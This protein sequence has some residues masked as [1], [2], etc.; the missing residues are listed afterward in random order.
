MACLWCS[1]K[2]HFTFS[3]LA[4]LLYIYITWEW[5]VFAWHHAHERPKLS[6][7]S[8]RNNHMISENLN[9]FIKYQSIS[10]G[11]DNIEFIFIHCRITRDI[12]FHRRCWWW[13]LINSSVFDFW[14]F[15][16]F[17]HIVYEKCRN[18]KWHWHRILFFSDFSQVFGLNDGEISIVLHLIALHHYHYRSGA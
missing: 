5:T 2:S 9:F 14:Y 10:S 13:K 4:K 15:L 17:G 16:L 12:P 8:C 1:K 3:I 11:C 7:H 18:P 6:K